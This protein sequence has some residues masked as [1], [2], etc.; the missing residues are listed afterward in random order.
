MGDWIPILQATASFAAPLILAGIAG[1]ICERSGVMNIGLEGKML[2][3][4]CIT[5]LAS[6]ATGSAVV[7]LLIGLA[8]T[9][10]LGLGHAILTQAFRIDHIISGMGIN[11]LALGFTGLLLRSH[12][13]F[14]G[15]PR[16]PSLSLNFYLALAFLLPVAVAL[17]LRSTR[18]GLR[19]LAI[20]NDPEKAR[21]SGLDPIRARYAALLVAG[22]LCGLAGALIVSN[23]GRFTEN[24]TD[25]RGYIALAAMIVAG[26]RPIGVLIACLGF[27]LISALQILLQGQVV[28]GIAI[29]SEFW[30]SLPYLVTILVLAG[31][32]GENRAP[33]GLGKP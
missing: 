4:A 1:L 23:S 13:A 32:V 18:G 31:L 16:M 28:F 26:W 19:L 9:M 27:G 12:P 2:T 5:A 29:P 8:V 24:M 30:L 25:G 3:A 20:G 10:L 33:S 6:L 17:Y 11:L 7:G 22:L 14:L 21:Q 15:N